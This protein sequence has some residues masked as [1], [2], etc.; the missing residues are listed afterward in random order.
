VEILKRLPEAVHWKRPIDWIL[1]HDKAPVLLSS[2]WSINGL[3]KWNTHPVSL[4]WLRMTSGYF[5]KIKSVL[6]W[7]TFRG[8]EGIRKKCNDGTES[9]STT[10]FPEMFPTVAASSR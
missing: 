10:G 2:L 3:L 1:N 4:I 5:Q 7:W 9:Y 6:Q 8:I